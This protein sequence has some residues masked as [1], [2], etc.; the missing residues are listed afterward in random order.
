MP[1]TV[2]LVH[3]IWM[4]GL[5]MQPLARR[6]RACGYR[7]RVF[8]YRSLWRPLDWN[9]RR[10]VR[11]VRKSGPGPVHLVGHSLGGLV[12]LQ[13][14][15]DCPDLVAGRVVLLGSPAN[16]SLIAQ[17]LYRRR[18]SR[19]LVGRSAEGGLLG[20]GPRWQGHTAPGV[21]AG[22][23]PLGVGQLLGGFSEQND[24]TVAL[25]ETVIDAAHPA[26]LVRTTHT[27][28]LFSAPVAQAVCRF[29]ATGR[30]DVPDAT[31]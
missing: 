30:F 10:L 1:D 22:T 28:L 26:M 15:Q 7:T 14:L 2:V 4:T 27:G 5:E 17:R 12:I 6:L 19:W 21:I 24:G 13:A 9:A 20:D 11:L 8:S 16:G 31:V 23:R 3:G 29:L 25:S 18:W